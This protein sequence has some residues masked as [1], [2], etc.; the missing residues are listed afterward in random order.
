MELAII[1]VMLIV[2][3]LTGRAIEKRHY[4][5]ILKREKE[6]LGIPV[7]TGKWEDL[8]QDN[9]EGKLLTGSVV[10]GS[11][12]FKTFAFNLR[13]LLGGRVKSYED[14]L[15]RGRRES[16]L[17]LKEKAK[18]WGADRVVNLRYE[19]TSIGG[20]EKGG[21][22]PCAEIFVYGTAIKKSLS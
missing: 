5:S 20:N 12:Y 15:D 4:V 14:L 9:E 10:I 21:S 17:R 11:S 7:L 6:L 18:S 16:L 3:Y 19:T 2:T 1:G 22:L 8:I 13:N